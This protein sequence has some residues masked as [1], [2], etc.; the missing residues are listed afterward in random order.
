[1]QVFPAC[2]P[3]CQTT[4]DMLMSPA[5]KAISRLLRNTANLWS[6][7][8]RLSKTKFAIGAGG[9]WE[10]EEVDSYYQ[11]CTQTL[12]NILIIFSFSWESRCEVFYRW[13][14]WRNFLG[15][16]SE[17]NIFFL[18]QKTLN[19]SRIT[20][21]PWKLLRH[22]TFIWIVGGGGGERGLSFNWRGN[23]QYMESQ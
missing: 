16:G 5:N 20:S 17:V 13:E 19:C 15:G 9:G 18:E 11:R 8:T 12:Q 7:Q 22:S 6:R 10:E 3:R 23:W 14:R 21:V 4:S 1:M 2:C